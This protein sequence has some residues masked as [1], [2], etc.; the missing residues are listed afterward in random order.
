M[1]PTI[2]TC[3]NDGTKLVIEPSA[4]K[5][6]FG[7]YQFLGVVGE[8]GMSVVYKAR[9]PD[10]NKIYAVKMLH[11][12]MV[13]PSAAGRFQ[14]EA[15]AAS[16]INHRNVITIHDYGTSSDGQPYIVMDFLEGEDLSD[17]IR[18]RGPMP[19]EQAIE[20]FIQI[21]DGLACAHK[22]G[23]VHRDLKPSNVVLCDET[24]DGNFVP[25]LVDFGIAKVVAESTGNSDQASSSGPALTRTGEVLG[26]PPY[27]SPE[28]CK[29]LQLDAR[30]DI[31]SFGCLMFEVLTGHTPFIGENF[32]EIVFKHMEDP[33]PALRAARP[34]REFPPRLEALVAKCLAKR[35]ADR[36]Q[37][38][39]EVQ[40]ELEQVYVDLRNPGR[41][42]GKKTTTIAVA[43]VGGALLMGVLVIAGLSLMKHTQPAPPP[44]PVAVTP[45]EPASSFDMDLARAAVQSRK[46]GNLITLD[47]NSYTDDVMRVVAEYNDIEALDLKGSAI[48]DK[49]LAF[50]SKSKSPIKHLNLDELNFV[51]SDGMRYLTGFP[52]EWLNIQQTDVKDEGIRE[53]GK[54]KTLTDLE[55]ARVDFG[56]D[57]LKALATLPKL[58]TLDVTLIPSMNEEWL[59]VLGQMHNLVTLDL[60]DNSV[61]DGLAYLG[62]LQKLK[63]LSLCEARGNPG[64]LTKLPVLPKLRRLVIA[65]TKLN[66][67]DLQSLRKQ[68]S[69]A[70][71][72]AGK[73]VIDGN[74]L[75]GDAEVPALLA[76]KNLKQLELRG[77]AVTA[78]GVRRLKALP[79]LEKIELGGCRNISSREMQDLRDE[80]API[81]IKTD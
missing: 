55:L 42:R 40:A 33:A 49:G 80:M 57:G 69:L 45:A 75:L 6:L 16:T 76:C 74:H 51:T 25:K 17:R 3:P 81:D 13:G 36:F 48:T 52:L 10:L 18:K 46:S 7:K 19:A 22:K 28:Q 50:L 73:I 31:Y 38:M 67:A 1:P 72:E 41:G 70:I 71:L 63:D 56:L 68:P 9:H 79:N 54:I 44:V 23:I 43:T 12:H 2:D 47:S 35:R 29:G 4:G 21:C 61:G 32:M 39:D 30:T 53:L 15:R 62:G 64:F 8:G 58:D 59:K 78:S 60:E 34:D 66:E 5:L 26:S 65:R 77:T 24:D 20:L 27:M 37:T 11:S 14:Q